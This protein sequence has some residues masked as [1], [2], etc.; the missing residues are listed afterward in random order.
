MTHPP[1]PEPD[2]P[3]NPLKRF[4]RWLKRPSTLMIGGGVLVLT[5][6]GGIW[7]YFW[8][9]RQLAP[10]IGRQLSEILNRPVRVGELEGL[11]FNGIRFGRSLV[12]ATATDPDRI[13]IEAIDV[14]FDL[15]PLVWNRSLPLQ[16]TLVRPNIY[17]EQNELGEWI[18]LELESKEESEPL[19]IELPTTIAVENAEIIL[20]SYQKTIPLQLT[21]NGT[22]TLSQQFKF[23]TYDFEVEFKQGQVHLMGETAIESGRTKANA[24]IQN[25]ALTSLDPVVPTGTPVNIAGGNINA[26]LAIDL[27][28]FE[29]LPSL[30]GT[31]RLDRA[32]IASD[33]LTGVAEASGLLRFQGQ[34]VRLEEV[35]A[36]YGPVSVEAGGSID[37]NRGFDVGVRVNPF[38]IAEVLDRFKIELPV[39]A[40]AML[41]GNFEIAGGLEN[42]EINGQIRTQGTTT[43]DR[44]DLAEIRVGVAIDRRQLILNELLV[45][46]RSGGTLTGTGQVQFP[47]ENGG[48]SAP[49]QWAFDM[50]ANLPVDA[51]A[52]AYGLPPNLSIG[53]LRASATVRGTP[54]TPEARLIWELPN[55]EAAIA[56]SR[57]PLSGG[58]EVVLKG[59]TLTVGDTRLQ[60]GDGAIVARANANLKTSQWQAFAQIEQF[61]LDPFVPFPVQ[62]SSGRVEASGSL[63]NPAPEAIAASADLEVAVAGGRVDLRGRLDEGEMTGLVTAS[64]LQ[65]QQVGAPIAIALLG[66]NA[67]ISGNIQNLDPT[68]IAVETDLRLGV[69]E[70]IVSARGRLDRGIVRM[71]AN[72]TPLELAEWIPDLPVPVS[73][74]ASQATVSAA[75]AD[76]L[77]AAETQDLSGIEAT[78]N[79]RLGVA[80]GTANAIARLDAGRLRLDADATAIALSPFVPDLPV[81]ASLST[82]SVQFSGAIADLLAA[83]ETR[84]LSGIEAQVEGNFAIADGTARAIARLEGNNVTASARSSAIDLTNL[85]PETEGAI[86]VRG[87]RLN[88]ETSVNELLQLAETQDFRGIRADGSVDLGIADGSARA[89]F[90]LTRGNF[91]LTSNASGINL[92]T[93][94]PTLPVP[95]RLNRGRVEL[96]AAIATWLDAAQRRNLEGIRARAEA[97]LGVADGRIDARAAIADL[98]W[99]STIALSGIDVAQVV[100]NLAIPTDRLAIAPDDTLDGRLE[101]SGALPS[102]F[103]LDG[104][105]LNLRAEAIDLRF[106]EQAIAADG[107][108]MLS[109][110]TTTPELARVDLD[111]RA[112][113]NLG[114]L[115]VV[116]PPDVRIRGQLAFDGRLRGTNLLSNPLAPGNF[117][118]VGDLDLD[119]FAL[120]EIVFD[121]SLSGSLTLE[122]GRELAIALRGPRDVIAARLDPCTRSDCP[123]PYLPA[124]VELRQGEATENPVIATGRRRGD[125]FNLAIENFPLALL[126]LSPGEDFGISGDLAGTVSGEISANLFTFETAGTLAIDRP[127][128]G[129]LQG[130]QFQV[131]F[132]YRDG[133]ARVSEATVA[134]GET[135][136]RF[137]G[138]VDL[139][140]GEL[141]GEAIVERGYIQDLLATFKWSSLS[142]LARGIQTPNRSAIALETAAVGESDATLMA[143]LRRFSEMS[144]FIEQIAQIR[145]A[146]GTPTELDLQGEYTGSVTVGGTLENPQVNFELKATDWKWR[147][148]RAFATITEPLGLAI[149][150]NRVIPIDLVVIRGGFNNGA[151]TVQPMRLEFSGTVVSF[152]GQLQ[153]QTLSGQF[154]LENLA[155]DTIRNFAEIPL[156]VHGNL[157]ASAQLSGTVENPQV[158]G[159]VS[160]SEGTLNGEALERLLASFSLS[161]KRARLATVEPSFMSLQ[162]SLPVPPVAGENE[163][164]AIDAN[165]GTEAIALMSA[166]SGGQLEWVAGEGQVELKARG[167]LNLA[168]GTVDD[169][170]AT[171]NVLLDEAIVNMAALPEGEVKINGKIA[172]TQDRIQVEQVAAEFAESHLSASGV[173]PLLQPFPV[174][175]PLTI[176]LD[177]GELKL[178]GLYEGEIGG[179]VVISGAALAPVIGGN[180]ELANAKVLVPKA[181]ATQPETTTVAETWAIEDGPAVE[182][183]PVVPRFDDFRVAIGDDFNIDG[184]PLYQFRITG[185]LLINGLLDDLRPQG[186]IYLKRGEIDV[187]SSQF[188]LTRAYDHRVTFDPNWGLDPFLDIQFGT[189][190]FETPRIRELQRENSEIR[191]DIVVSPRPDQIKIT[192]AVRGR[193]SEIIAEMENDSDLID[194]VELSSIPSRTESQILALLGG[195]FLATIEELEGQSPRE[196]VEFAFNRYVIQPVIR[197]VLFTVEEFVSGVGQKMGLKDLQVYPVVEALYEVGD[198]ETVGISYDYT[199]EQFEVKYRINF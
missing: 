44:V 94:V 126:Q 169:L 111:V 40:Q 54:E 81:E 33:S 22:A 123:A 158:R 5:T 43:I 107:T 109:N 99:N 93:L 106:G 144:A 57:F 55:A 115:P 77:A 166:F 101:L 182:S 92:T 25:L 134:L 83:A 8:L 146:P 80:G 35:R 157:N 12:P 165:L 68:A 82:A 86:A 30:S 189:L 51:I 39:A 63:K 188:F 194:V 96:S 60:I 137:Q 64:S 175:N 163:E 71:S 170:V 186:T 36:S 74:L 171:G 29:E 135:R 14:G 161:D 179:K 149:E 160:F 2:R 26:N 88:L 42:P 52:S 105:T 13:S 67:R 159:E 145:R 147:P 15:S 70:A 190:A 196:L 62:L 49:M 136:Y 180:L 48:E 84:D 148:K 104:A 154:R 78:A 121:P 127:T 184:S 124:F 119:N 91:N 23:A 18:N 140:T 16:I 11:S 178:D 3:R 199:F 183:A 65:L 150:E 128:L 19:P 102:P 155:L 168:A 50:Q 61:P 131:K 143:Q 173:L 122:P 153:P 198:N 10:L 110:L 53:T 1:T 142:D 47:S 32:Q 79:L 156:D 59:D 114:R 37:L 118:L 185:D 193:S 58:G 27:A 72:S 164:I 56:S 108:L 125:R 129:Y 34:I 9:D 17:L 6:A 75:I 116:L 162:A 167:N 38:Q 66:G 28:S 85:I 113:S 192:L 45:R 98:N 46:P 112:R 7:G 138:G 195:Q 181:E 176:A 20:L 21:V 174:E 117:Q 191:E 139:N 73:L 132:S 151:V 133:V 172:L 69:A 24:R 90:A 89:Q 76:L 152:V 120:N 130:E 197:D 87:S 103:D 177:R 4:V 41:T 141:Q 95:V 100:A 31:F 97:D 187:F